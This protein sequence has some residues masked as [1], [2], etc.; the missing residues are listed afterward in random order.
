M[1]L[2]TKD[3]ATKSKDDAM[4]QVIKSKDETIIQIEKKADAI[5]H[6]KEERLL[7]QIRVF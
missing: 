1:I 7:N 6:S 4:T 3:E 2:K 5:T